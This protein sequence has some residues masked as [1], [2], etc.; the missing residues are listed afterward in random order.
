MLYYLKSIFP[1]PNGAKYFGAQSLLDQN[2]YGAQINY[3]SQN[4]RGPTGSKY[5]RGPKWKILRIEPAGSVPSIS[6]WRKILTG[7]AEQNTCGALVSNYLRVKVLD[8][9]ICKMR[10]HRARWAKYL[11]SPLEQISL[12]ARAR[13]YFDLPCIIGY[14]VAI[15]FAISFSI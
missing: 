8:F 10:F 12:W 9:V 1:G 13:K 2:T 3:H 11:W 5:L 14:I 6:P 15:Q 7:P 4:T